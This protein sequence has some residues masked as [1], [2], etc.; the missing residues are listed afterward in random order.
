M[1]LAVEHGRQGDVGKVL[2][3][4]EPLQ[5]EA[6][7][8]G[9]VGVALA[10]AHLVVV[11]LHLL[12]QSSSLQVLGNLLTAG[13]A[14]HAHID[15]RLVADGSVGVED[16]DG[17]QVV[18]LAQHI[19]VLIVGRCHL[20]TARSELDVHV[21]VFDDGNLAVHQWDD[22]LAAFQP[23]VLRILGVD[24]HG[25]IAHDGLR[26]R[27]GHD[28]VIAA[29][30]LVDDSPLLPPPDGGG[31]FRSGSLPHRGEV[32]GG[33]CH[34]IFQVI[35]LGVFLLVDHFLVAQGGEGLRIPI[36]HAEATVDVAF[37]IEVDKDLDD[38]L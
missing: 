35:K 4:Q 6:R 20:Q 17:L 12:H 19:I 5:R 24:A 15:G 1:H 13:E 30:V 25:G 8:D 31:S 2:H 23:L 34:V 10:V 11:V 7:L 33:P 27:S 37:A 16:V 18:G 32:G 22:D 21:A 36:H 3:L 9:R 26:T 28:S 14:I 29:L 38:A